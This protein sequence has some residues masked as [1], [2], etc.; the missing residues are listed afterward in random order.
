MK[1]LLIA[2]LSVS[3]LAS[4]GINLDAIPE[5]RTGEVLEALA[6]YE[7]F[8]YEFEYRGCEAL[9][10]ICFYWQPEGYYGRALMF[11]PEPWK[12]DI[13][14]SSSRVDEFDLTTVVMH[15][16]GHVL[17]CWQHSTGL[18]S[19]NPTKGSKLALEDQRKLRG[20]HRFIPPKPSGV[21]R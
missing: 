14:I 10:T 13:I 17:G 11:H 6:Y 5:E 1:L 19:S 3:S 18:M 20:N 9:D 15:E 16:L 12:D 2:V 7:W 4:I 8:G 21:F